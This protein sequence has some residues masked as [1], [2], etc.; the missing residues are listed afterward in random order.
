MSD[1]IQKKANTWISG[2]KEQIA[3]HENATFSDW[4]VLGPIIQDPLKVQYYVS[5]APLFLHIAGAI[6]C[7]GF[8]AIFHLFKDHRPKTAEWL[9]RLDYA[10]IS[11]MIA[12]SNMP[13]LFYSFY[14]KPMHSKIIIFY[15]YSLEKRVHESLKCFL[16]FGVC[17]FSMA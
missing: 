7:L 1:L 14:C 15:I 17:C 9:V 10:G 4:L 11:L 5:K 13:P 2:I 16:L 6:C 3:K 8:S 12:G